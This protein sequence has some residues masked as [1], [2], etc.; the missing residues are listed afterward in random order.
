VPAASVIAL[1]SAPASASAA[2]IGATTLAATNLSSTGATLN[3]NVNAGLTSLAYEFF[4]GTT[5]LSQHTDPG[6]VTAGTSRNVSAALGGLQPGTT[7]S[8]MLV[9]LVPGSSPAQY[10]YGRTLTFTTSPFAGTDAVTELATSIKTTSA[11]LNGT[12]N[13]EGSVASYAFQYGST[14]SY[15]QTTA[16]TPIQGTGAMSVKASISGLAPGA[17]YHYRLIELLRSYPSPT[18]ELGSDATVTTATSGR[19]GSSAL[20][21]KHATASLTSSRISVKRGIAAM[22][23]KCTGSKGA[24][25]RGKVSITA[26]GKIGGRTK[27]VS[28]G[29][30]TY[31]ASAGSTRTV[32]GR[33]SSGCATLLKKAKRHALHATFTG[34]FSTQLNG[35]RA[36]VTLQ[37]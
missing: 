32:K 37:G 34:T 36:G 26:R 25:C 15:G 35:L 28:C 23:L 24:V 5:S 11:T 1:G 21:G 20:T 3:G 7:Y 9:V 31:A 12:V 33:L 14:T 19:L 13:T 17:T 2:P 27:T 29:S 30:G 8:F 10:S 4:Y 16:A 22:S 18:L 6:T